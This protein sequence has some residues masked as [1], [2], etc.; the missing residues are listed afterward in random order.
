MQGLD[1]L[2][3]ETKDQQLAP[4]TDLCRIA[5]EFTENVLCGLSGKIHG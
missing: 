5:F 1:R 3:V 2:L 4:V